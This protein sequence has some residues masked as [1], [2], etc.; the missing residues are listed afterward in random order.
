VNK[1]YQSIRTKATT[2]DYLSQW[3]WV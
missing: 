3:L 1:D 2:V